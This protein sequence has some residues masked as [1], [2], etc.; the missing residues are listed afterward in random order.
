MIRPDVILTYEPGL[1]FLVVVA[2]TLA[3]RTRLVHDTVVAVI[4]R[5]NFAR[6]YVSR[7]AVVR[8]DVEPTHKPGPAFVVAVTITETGSARSN[9]LAEILFAT[10]IR[11]LL[12]PQV[13]YRAR[14]KMLAPDNA[15][16]RPLENRRT[17]Q[18]HSDC[19][20]LDHLA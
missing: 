18:Q 14:R 15:A 1:A 7:E 6:I 11:H 19:R 5:T 10:D 20:L 2:I 9:G 8:P 3:R 4:H 17:D 13:E 12:A 16:S